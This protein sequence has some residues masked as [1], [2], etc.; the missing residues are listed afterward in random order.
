MA[1]RRKVWRKPIVRCRRH[2]P[3]EVVG[4]VRA[5]VSYQWVACSI[6]GN[7]A[8]AAPALERMIEGGWRPVKPWRHP[9]MKKSGGK[10]VVRGQVLMERPEAITLAARQEETNAGIQMV[11]QSPLDPRKYEWGDDRKWSAFTSEVIAPVFVSVKDVEYEAQ[12][13]PESGGHLYCRINV[14]VTV[15]AAEIEMALYLKLDPTEYIRRR[16]V[17]DTEALVKRTVT[18]PEKEHLFS[19]AEFQTKTL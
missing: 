13:L 7:K 18:T 14:P 1:K 16:I 3:F 8:L 11:K 6:M 2:D 17:M 12:K 4:K 9:R 10:I 5:G 19:R 15:S